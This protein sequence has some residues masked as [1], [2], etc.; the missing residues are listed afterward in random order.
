MSIRI[1]HLLSPWSNSIFFFNIESM[2]SVKLPILSW[3]DISK[4]SLPGWG[5][6][7]LWLSQVATFHGSGLPEGLLHMTEFDINMSHFWYHTREA[8]IAEN[9]LRHPRGVS[10][11][12]SGPPPPPRRLVAFSFFFFFFPFQFFLFLGSARLPCCLLPSRGYFSLNTMRRMERNCALVM[13]WTMDA[14]REKKN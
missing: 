9:F 12:T 3:D 13:S 8:F 6:V 10:T 2:K 11:S 5:L 1:K 7:A 4:I 14:K